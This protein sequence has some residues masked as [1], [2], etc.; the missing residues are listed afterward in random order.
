MSNPFIS[1]LGDVLINAYAYLKLKDASEHYIHFTNEDGPGD[2]ISHDNFEKDLLVKAKVE[3]TTYFKSRDTLDEV[4]V[5]ALYRYV[6]QKL[7]TP[8]LSPEKMEQDIKDRCLS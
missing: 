2:I 6:R 1:T 3:A 5:R 4:E 8:I 7:G